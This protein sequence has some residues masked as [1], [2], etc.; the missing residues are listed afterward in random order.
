MEG[1]RVWRV[2]LQTDRQRLHAPRAAEQANISE[3][4]R[5]RLRLVDFAIL[6]QIMQLGRREFRVGEFDACPGMR[7][8]SDIG[9]EG[10]CE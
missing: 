5:R 7:F 3:Q 1:E 6:R 10:I 9:R 2:V 8:V 4:I